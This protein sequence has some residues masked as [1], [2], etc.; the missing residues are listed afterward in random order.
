MQ[1]NLRSLLASNGGNKTV[2]LR[3]ELIYGHGSGNY[4]YFI[5]MIEDT[6]LRFAWIAKV[7]FAAFFTV[8]N[9]FISIF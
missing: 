7:T 8:D 6:I 2:Q 3:D 9:T 4:I 1:P 5:A